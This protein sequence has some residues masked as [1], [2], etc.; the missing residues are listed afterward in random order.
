MSDRMEAILYRVYVVGM[1][2]AVV[3][4]IAMFAYDYFKFSM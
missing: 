2:F 1:V 3:G 4:S